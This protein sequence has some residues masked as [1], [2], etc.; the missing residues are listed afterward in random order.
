LSNLVFEI[1]WSCRDLIV[2]GAIA[3]VA[4][5]VGW[6]AMW[7]VAKMRCQFSTQHPLHQ[8][9]LQ[10]LSVKSWVCGSLLMKVPLRKWF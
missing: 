8:P 7:F 10:I 6:F 3:T 9:D 5:L 4:L 1:L 2:C